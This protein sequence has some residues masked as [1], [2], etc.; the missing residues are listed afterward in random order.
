MAKLTADL[1]PIPQA[2]EY[3]FEERAG[4][5]EFMGGIPREQA[6]REAYEE[7]VEGRQQTPVRVPLSKPE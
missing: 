7:V 2:L 1:P 5:K 4:I 3:E 6:E